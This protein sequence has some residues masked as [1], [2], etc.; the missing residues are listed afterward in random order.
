MLRLVFAVLFILGIT[1]IPR[2][3]PKTRQKLVVDEEG[4]S[5]KID[6]DNPLRKYILPC[7]IGCGVIAAFLIFSTSFVIIDAAR[8]GHL[9]R[10][11]L[12][13]PMPPG[14][15]VAFNGQKGPQ[16]EILPP[17][18]H[19]R[20]LLNVLFDVEEYP[21]IDIKE[22]TYGYMVA[23]DGAP[24]REGQY[25]ADS[26]PNDQFQKMLQAEYF[27]KTGGQKGPQLTVLPPGKYR[28]NQYLFNIQLNEATDI[29]AGFVGVIKSNVQETESYELAQIPFELEGSLAV[30]LVTKGSVGVWEDPLQPGRYYLNRTAYNVTVVDT[31][32]QTWNYKGGYSRRY[33]DLQVTQDG[34]IEQKER[35]ETVSI[36]EDAADSAI[37]TRME[38]WLVPQELRIQVQVEPKDAPFLVAS[39]GNVAAAEDK[40]VTPSIRSVVRNICAAERVLSLIDEN[41]AA[42]EQRIEASVIP[43]GKKAGVT[44]KD[45]RL[46]DSVVPP[47]LL[48]ARLREQLAEQLQETF[49]REREA[50]DQR[51]QTQKAR[52]TAD[53]QPELVAAE[54]R[55]KIAEKDK[56]AAKL[57]G[58][59]Q[60]LKLIEIAT[61]QKAQSTVLGQERVMQLAVLEKV[62][63][64]AVENPEIVKI[65]TTLVTGSTGGFEGAAAILG[66]SNI[67]SGIPQK[68]EAAKAPQ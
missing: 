32:V 11:Y 56:L 41:R 65:P 51:I 18:F 47:E 17:G 23:K 66:A 15:I 3:I 31:R 55:V 59:G 62:L 34:K 35:S 8:I 22:G 6:E 40:V 52:A 14:Q 10:I 24:L 13:E 44:I 5:K 42:V 45:V 64:A 46:V 49:K 68:Q 50:Q 53:Q 2:L 58:E 25:L 61:G 30:P 48:V 37:F 43:E 19:F 27:L 26:W 39:V 16:A 38:G 28:L 54:I 63:N 57:E 21:V 33:I 9:K 4:N 12:G 60:K 36:P 29:P 20:L 67:A 1:L 7:Q